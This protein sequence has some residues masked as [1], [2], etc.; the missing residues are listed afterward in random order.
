MI[1]QVLCVRTIFCLVSI[2]EPVFSFWTNSFTAGNMNDVTNSGTGMHGCPKWANYFEVDN[3]TLDCKAPKLNPR[4]PFRLRA[5]NFCDKICEEVN[6]MVKLNIFVDMKNIF[7]V[8][9]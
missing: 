7:M 9:Q 4:T 2:S 3:S 6:L 1:H 8:K 5:D